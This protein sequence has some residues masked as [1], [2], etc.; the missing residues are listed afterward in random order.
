MP[1]LACRF[2]LFALIHSLFSTDTVKSLLCG[3]PA[4]LRYYRLGYNI[5]AL[6]S[7]AWVLTALPGSPALYALQGYPAVI[8]SGTQALSLLLLC[9]CAAQTGLG[10][11]T[12]IRQL[13]T[14][15]ESPPQFTRSGGYGLVRHPQYTLAMIFLFAAPTVSR[16]HLLFTLLSGLYFVLGAYLEERRLLTT[17]GDDYLRYRREVPMFIPRLR[18]LPFV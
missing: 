5:L 2:I 3:H 17:F 7:F 9:R 15:K 6:V 11:F 13:L 16:N 14:G 18:R 4:A 12:G 1:A 10:E 8:L